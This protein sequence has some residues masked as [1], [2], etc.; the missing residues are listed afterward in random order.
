MSSRETAGR[1]LSYGRSL[2]LWVAW[3]MLLVIWLATLMRHLDRHDSAPLLLAVTTVAL[4]VLLSF[5]EG[6]ELAVADLLDKDASQVSDRRTRDLLSAIQRRSG[7]FFAQRQVFV[8]LIV[9]FASLATSYDWIYVPFYGETHDSSVTFW[10]SLCF[11]TLTVLWFSQV[12]PKRLAVANSEAF[13]GYSKFVWTAIRAISLLGLPG[14]TDQ[15]FALSRR[16]PAFRHER[17]LLPS[18]SAHYNTSAHLYGFAL[19]KLSTDLSIGRSGAATVRKKFLI[20]FLYGRHAHVYGYVDTNSVFRKP[21]VITLKSMHVLP[22]PER[23]ESMTGTL[24]A[25]FDEDTSVLNRLGLKNRI[26]EWVGSVEVSIEESDWEGNG[27]HAIWLIQGQPLPE[28]CWPEAED[29][30]PVRPLVAFLYEVEA[31]SDTGAFA[32]VDGCYMWQETIGLP[33]REYDISIVSDREADLGI[34]IRECRVALVG[35]GTEIPEETH[36]LTRTAVSGKDRMR[37]IY[38]VQGAEYSLLW[39]EFKREPESSW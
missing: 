12:T 26:S 22:T 8:V 4:L 38:P 37:V 18:R 1:M 30:M 32:E 31:E 34:A 2:I 5:A 10:F 35:P 28:S 23:L 29:D 16:I 3:V 19:D 15:L 33:C 11:V 25:I 14:P 13:L 36:K 27:Q 17:M 39:W 20:L 6:M 7:F 21:P 24:D 9:S